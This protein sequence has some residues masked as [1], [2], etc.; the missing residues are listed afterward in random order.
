MKKYPVVWL[1]QKMRSLSWS[2]SSNRKKMIYQ[3]ERDSIKASFPENEDLDHLLLRL[4]IKLAGIYLP[5][6]LESCSRQVGVTFERSRVG[7]Q[8]TRWGSCSSRRVISLNWRILLLDY[9]VGEYVLYHE[10]AHLKH[11][12]HSSKYWSLL[13]SWVSG[14]KELDKSL[15]FQGRSL[16]LLGR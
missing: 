1:D 5:S 9:K 11:M 16:M 7:N 4:L 14:A 8:R 3:I 6:R 15:S 2:V 10:L 13:E 12:N